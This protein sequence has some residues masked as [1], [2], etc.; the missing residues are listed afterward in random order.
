MPRKY[1]IHVQKSLVRYMERENLPWSPIGNGKIRKLKSNELA[2]FSNDLEQRAGS[3]EIFIPLLSAGRLRGIT[4]KMRYSDDET[5]SGI[6]QEWNQNTASESVFLQT[7]NWLIDWLSWTKFHVYPYRTYCALRRQTVRTAQKLKVPC[8]ARPA[9][10][11]HVQLDQS[12]NRPNELH[13]VQILSV[14][15][16]LLYLLFTLS[17]KLYTLEQPT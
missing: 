9:G 2:N 8:T 11:L 16:V 1:L 5:T 12:S 13:G 6:L 7:F 17:T 3:G 4:R 14:L 10:A 15:P